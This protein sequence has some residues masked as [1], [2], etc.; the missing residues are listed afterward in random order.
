MIWVAEIGSNHKGIPALAHEMIRQSAKAGATIAKF[1]FG[2]PEWG[3]ETT[4]YNGGNRYTKTTLR[5]IRYVDDWAPELKEWCDYYDIELMASIWSEEGLETAKSVD[6][7]RYKIAHQI[8]EEHDDFAVRVLEEGKETFV[9]AGTESV[10][11]EINTKGKLIFATEDY[12]TYPNNIYMP[13]KFGDDE[14]YYGYS[15]HTP[16]YADALLAISRGAKYIEKHVTLNK[17]EDSI[18]DNAFSLSFE[19]FKLMLEVGTELERLV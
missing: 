16:G 10:V 17:T 18:R 2:W 3:K 6:M 1:Q 13:D 9:S 4:V 19:E 11:K 14:F 5:N 12:P 15:S 7:K 8:A